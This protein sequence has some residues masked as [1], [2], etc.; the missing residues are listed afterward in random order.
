[1]VGV[2]EG[3]GGA[4]RVLV[5]V[6]VGLFV[7]SGVSLGVGLG[8]SVGTGV[9]VGESPGVGVAVVVLV[10]EAVKVAVGAPAVRVCSIAS[11]CAMAVPTTSG[12]GPQAARPKASN[13]VS[14][15]RWLVLVLGLDMV[16]RAFA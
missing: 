2:A 12:A 16:A 6:G 11:V 14:S 9:A 5:T 10:G 8:V 15:H 4:G 3:G 7:G 13:S 1:L